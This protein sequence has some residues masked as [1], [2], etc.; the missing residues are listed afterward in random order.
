MLLKF[1]SKWSTGNCDLGKTL[2]LR[3]HDENVSEN[4]TIVEYYYACHR[5]HVKTL[6][7]SFE[8]DDYQLK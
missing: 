4:S 8:N 2:I 7:I 5:H 3:S 6:K 1:A